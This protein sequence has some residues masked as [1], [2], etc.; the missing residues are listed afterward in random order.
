MHMSLNMLKFAAYDD[1]FVAFVD[2]GTI[3]PL[4]SLDKAAEDNFLQGYHVFL[5]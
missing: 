4:K 5:S 3:S 1:C 2:D